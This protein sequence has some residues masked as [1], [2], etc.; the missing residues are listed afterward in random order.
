MVIVV[1]AREAFLVLR[2]S[3]VVVFVMKIVVILIVERHF[4][5]AAFMLVGAAGGACA[6]W[7][8]AP[9]RSVAIVR[10][11]VAI[12]FVAIARRANRVVTVAVAIICYATN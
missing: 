6:S 9:G 7:A 8:Q 4:A 5:K 2:A 11:T 3:R 12:V 10:T 1:A